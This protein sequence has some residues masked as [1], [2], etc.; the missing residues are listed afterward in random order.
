M[1]LSV[2]LSPWLAL[3]L[4]LAVAAPVC[5][6]EEAPQ[7]ADQWAEMLLLARAYLS[8]AALPWAQACL[9][10]VVVASQLA[11]VN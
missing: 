11:R 10:V 7:W 6:S 2:A 4:W 3:L 5:L 9:S 8:V 1:Y